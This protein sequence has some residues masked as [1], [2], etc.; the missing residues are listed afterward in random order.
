[1]STDAERAFSR[2]GLTVSKMRHSLSNQSS[3]TATV[4]GA[5]CSLPSAIPRDEIMAVFRDK[6]KRPKGNNCASSATTLSLDANSSTDAVVINY[7]TVD[8]CD[9]PTPLFRP[10]ESM[11]RSRSVPAMVCVI[12]QLICV[13]S[14]L[15]PLFMQLVCGGGGFAHRAF[16]LMWLRSPFRYYYAWSLFYSHSDNYNVRARGEGA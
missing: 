3:R 2:G 1:M 6:N 16:R 11:A 14:S 5:W 9:A 7:V 8:S 10:H 4:L 13:P 12:S 15:G